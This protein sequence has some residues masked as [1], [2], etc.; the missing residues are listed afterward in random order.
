MNELKVRSNTNSVKKN[1]ELQ[2]QELQ[3]QVWCHEILDT[4]SLAKRATLIDGN[5]E[6]YNKDIINV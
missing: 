4:A 1:Y 5:G 2:I 6:I 3:E